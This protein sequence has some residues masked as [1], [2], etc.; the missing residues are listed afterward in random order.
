M[1]RPRKPNE[2]TELLDAL[3]M[4]DGLVCFMCGAIHSRAA[5][6]AVDRIDHDIELEEK[7]D[8]YIVACK[9]CVRRR[10]KRPLLAYLKTRLRAARAEVEYLSDLP[11]EAK[12]LQMLTRP[13]HYTPRITPDV[14]HAV[15]GTG[16]AESANPW[17]GV[18][19]TLYVE[20]RML[21]EDY[22]T[23]RNIDGPRNPKHGDVYQR[24]DYHTQELEE[25]VFDA[26]T[27][28]WRDLAKMQEGG[29]FPADWPPANA[30]VWRQ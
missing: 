20:E 29:L 8:N 12:I 7:T 15:D 2:Q 27:G 26:E 6:M 16:Q 13:L 21:P 1:A 25:F 18:V 28:R 5:T 24:E 17:D 22:E 30:V 3:A 10:D 11:T 23:G 19:P 9:T 14:H 4:R